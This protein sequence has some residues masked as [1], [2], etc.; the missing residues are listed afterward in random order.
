MTM[1]ETSTPDYS[2]NRLREFLESEAAGGIVLMLASALA[3]IV[4]NSPLARD[5]FHL[6]HAELGPLSVHHWINDALMAVFFLLVGLEIKA[7]VTEGQLA[8]W[9]QRTLPV[10]AAAS[11][12]VVPALVYLAVTMGS[13]GLARGWA[14][15]AATDIAFAMGLLGLLGKR[16]PAALKL[17]LTTIAIVD[18]MGA[19]LIIALAYTAKLNLVALLGA[20]IA[21]ACMFALG[22]MGVK[23]LAPYLVLGLLLWL[24]IYASGVHATI[25]GVA[26]AMMIPRAAAHRLEHALNPWVAF[27]IVPLFGF[28]N[29]GVSLGGLGPEVLQAPLPLGVALGLFAGKQIGVFGSIWL[30]VRLKIAPCPHARWRQIYGMALL[31]GIGFTMSLF[32]GGLA[33]PGDAL[34]GDEVKIGVLA[35]SVLSALAGYLVLR[36]TSTATTST[37]NPPSE[38]SAPTQP[39]DVQP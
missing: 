13:P 22:R 32:I 30:A 7:E 26:T 29:A 12:M 33:F 18:D 11:G 36:S 8:S 31:A 39:V 34:L 6:L 27:A 1:P 35:G 17:L 5:Y 20:G 28:A 23:R 16:A 4:A 19:V 14:I 38:S 24:A 15:P 25:A 21:L 10:I 9:S 3:L 37:A 2:R